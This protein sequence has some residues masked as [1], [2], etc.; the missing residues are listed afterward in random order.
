MSLRGVWADHVSIPVAVG[1]LQWDIMIVTSAPCASPDD[2][3]MWVVGKDGLF[4]EHVL[5]G[6]IHENHCESLEPTGSYHLAATSSSADGF[7]L[8]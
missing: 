8:N 1:M 3:I 2:I 7:V 5:L 4:Y 6:Y